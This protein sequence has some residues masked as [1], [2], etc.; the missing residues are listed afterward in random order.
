LDAGADDAIEEDGE[1]IVYTDPKALAQVRDALLEQNLEI[2]EAE[3]TFV[4]NN[5]VAVDD[6][7]TLGKIMRVMDA[8]DELDDVVNT[9]TNFA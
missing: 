3:L 6:E 1:T 9:H 4:P 8:L 5:T 7:A 2:T